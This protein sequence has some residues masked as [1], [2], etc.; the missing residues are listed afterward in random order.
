MSLLTQFYPGPGGGGDGD[1]VTGTAGNPVLTWGGGTIGGVGA[2]PTS[3]NGGDWTATL[4]SAAASPSGQNPAWSI[5]SSVSFVSTN[6]TTIASHNIFWRASLNA[7]SCPNLE[8]IVIN[9]STFAAGISLASNP[10]LTSIT[11]TG[12]FSQTLNINSNTALTSPEPDG[13]WIF[14]FSVF[15]SFQQNSRYSPRG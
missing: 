6:N 3:I 11:G 10:S 13:A 7:T 12:V 4:S 1:L 14:Y 5:S 9:G 15:R 2:A 8:T